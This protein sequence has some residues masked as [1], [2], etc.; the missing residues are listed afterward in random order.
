MRDS[1]PLFPPWVSQLASAY[2]AFN[3]PT[4]LHTTENTQDQQKDKHKDKK[5][6]TL[7]IDRRHRKRQCESSGLSLY[8]HIHNM[9]YIYIYVAFILPTSSLNCTQLQNL[10]ICFCIFYI[11]KI[12]L[13][14]ILRCISQISDEKLAHPILKLPRLRLNHTQ[15]KN[16]LALPGPNKHFPL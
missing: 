2:S 13:P 10:F 12:H 7:G 3:L 9:Y 14:D 6:K 11:P 16:T 1:S 4:E 5:T 15:P 8:V